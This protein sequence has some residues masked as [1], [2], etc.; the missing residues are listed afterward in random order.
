[1]EGDDVL[2]DG[3]ARLFRRQ[4]DADHRTEDSS[5][6]ATPPRVIAISESAANAMATGRHVVVAPMSGECIPVSEV[7]DPVFACEALGS[8]VAIIPASGTVVSPVTGTVIALIDTEHA[9]C[10]RSDDGIEVLVHCGIDT[11]EMRGVSFS[12]C[13]AQGDHVIAGQ[14]L[15][16]VDLDAIKAAGKEIVTPVIVTNQSGFSSLEIDCGHPVTAGD[17]VMTL[18]R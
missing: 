7:A 10:L 9:I 16:D 15:M 11:V 3:I 1:M 2:I 6:A 13:V 17:L 8:G 5:Y 12:A 18:E 4:R 14:V